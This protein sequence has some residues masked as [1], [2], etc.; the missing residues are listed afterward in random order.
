M[1]FTDVK[2]AFDSFDNG[3]VIDALIK[4]GASRKTVVLIKSIY[5]KARAVVLAGHAAGCLFDIGRGVLEGDILSP[6]LFIV[7][8]E[9]TFREAGTDQSAPLLRGI[10]V[11]QIG[12]AD[13][14]ILCS[15]GGMPRVQHRFDQ[16]S[17]CLERRGLNFSEKKGKCKLMHGG[18]AL[19]TR[20]P[21]SEDID[22]LNLK[23]K[24]KCKFCGV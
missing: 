8:L 20:A 9:V 18:P 1:T 2:M 10:P 23:Y 7:G 22:G 3:A 5:E 19:A 24:Y 21:T 15:T 13:D 6:L 12:F 11:S 4:A 17:V 16:V 14:V